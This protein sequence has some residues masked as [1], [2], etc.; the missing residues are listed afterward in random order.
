DLV[1]IRRLAEME[2][3]EN[4]RF[5]RFLK[6]HH[7]PQDLFRRIAREVEQQI[8]CKAC[9]NC[10][11]EPRVNV[12]QEDVDTLAR[13]LDMTPEQVLKEYTVVDAEDH[14]RILGQTSTGCVFLDGN[15]C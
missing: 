6:A 5:R 13:Y 12:S 3:G 9:A 4:I 8:D 2:E 10:C 7:Y 11:R 1:Q 14:S 15:L